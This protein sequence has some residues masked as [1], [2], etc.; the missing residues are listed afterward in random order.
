MKKIIIATLAIIGIATAAVAQD[1]TEI[2]VP[3]GYQGFLDQTS[4]YRVFDDMSTSVGLSTTHGFYFNGHTFIGVGFG[5]EGGDG[6]FAMPIYTALK[7]NFSYAKTASPT[8]QARVGSYV[9]EHT[10][11]YADLA[12][13]VRFASK[14]DF[15]VN[16]MLAGSF[17]EGAINDQLGVIEEG[18]VQSSTKKYNPTS[19]GLRV[20]IEW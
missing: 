12:F 16:L 6:F 1:N 3:S 2:R 9:S 4:L 19:I 13:G 7:Y 17:Y 20:G 18:R 14:R 10:G 5:I 8:I 15:A 11:A